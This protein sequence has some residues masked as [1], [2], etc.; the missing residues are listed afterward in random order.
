MYK[1]KYLKY[2]N[3]YLSFKI[4][5]EGSAAVPDIHEAFD[6]CKSAPDGGPCER[7]KMVATYSNEEIWFT[8]DLLK[9]EYKTFGTKDK[10][11]GTEG[12]PSGV[13][14][15]SNGSW[16]F[17]PILNLDIHNNTS[18]LT[19]SIIKCV[20]IKKPINIL[21]I[22]TFEVLDKF[23]DDYCVKI[24]DMKTNIKYEFIEDYK[25]K[26][27]N[28]D[29][30]SMV[31]AKHRF[32]KLKKDIIKYFA[33]EYSA[34]FAFNEFNFD[35]LE[36]YICDQ[37]DS[38]KI[39]YIKVCKEYI[40]QKFYSENNL[41]NE[42]LDDDYKFIAIIQR[43]LLEN[44]DVIIYNYLSKKPDNYVPDYT[45]IRWDDISKNYHGVAF[46]F[47][48]VYHIKHSEYDTYKFKWHNDYFVES[49]MIFDIK[50]L[51]D[52]SIVCVD[53]DTLK[54]CDKGTICNESVESYSTMM[55][56]LGDDMIEKKALKD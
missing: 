21:K 48:K 47:R 3:K 16:L 43:F 37:F 17:D 30:D 32:G 11:F 28:P 27:S 49:L 24:P 40:L 42:D 1:N 12:K 33:D 44:S 38:D 4:G 9:I 50:A 10:T 55:S 56:K 34:I 29:I 54:I 52:M 36:K 13:W 45:R 31:I 53:I 35:E 25:K 46:N 39:N 5:G 7:C 26:L 19:K 8:T 18:K 22:N 51:S 14:W 15:F 41:D 2:K 6:F 23:V 20:M